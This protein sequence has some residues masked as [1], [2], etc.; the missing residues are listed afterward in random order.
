M[1]PLF[2][3]GVPSAIVALWVYSLYPILRNTYSGVRD[4]SPESVESAIALG[5][6]ERQVLVNV[7]LPLAAP[8]IMAGIRTAAVLVV[9]TATLSTY[10]GA[11]GLGDTINIGLQMDQPSVVLAGAIPTALLAIA[12]DLILGALE[13]VVKPRGRDVR[14]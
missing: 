13:R 1:I 12:V 6:T 9:G 5:M 4:A 3:I 8:V 7:R 2:G 11:G 14:V 10:I